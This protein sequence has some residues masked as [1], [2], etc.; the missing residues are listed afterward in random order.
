MLTPIK[1]KGDEHICIRPLL[2]VIAYKSIHYTNTNG[3]ISMLIG[4]EITCVCFLD[5]LHKVH[6]GGNHAGSGSF[7]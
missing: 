4:S 6:I 1:N 5:I 7:A 3:L 2:R